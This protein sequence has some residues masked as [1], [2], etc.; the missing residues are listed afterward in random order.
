[1]CNDSLCVC[2]RVCLRVCVTNIPGLSFVNLS[3]LLTGPMS[4]A[5]EK[6]ILTFCEFHDYID[7]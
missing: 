5:L 4:K 1:M 3:D 2:V 6:K 7:S